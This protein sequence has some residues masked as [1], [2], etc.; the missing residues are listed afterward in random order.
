[1]QQPE[2]ARSSSFA[3]SFFQAG[4]GNDHL[5]DSYHDVNDAGG[6]G[7]G[8]QGGGGQAV[9]GSPDGGGS[10]GASTPMVQGADMQG[11]PRGAMKRRSSRRRLSRGSGG[12]SGRNLMQSAAAAA[13]AAAAVGED[14]P[15]SNLPHVG[16]DPKVDR[17]TSWYTDALLQ[18]GSDNLNAILGQVQDETREEANMDDDEVLEQY[19]IMAHV[20]ANI[21]VKENTGF[22][23]AEYE[24]R[25]K[26]QPETGKKGDYGSKRPKARLP[27]PRKVTNSTRASMKA[28]EPPM[29]NP[30]PNRRFIDQRTPRVPELCPGIVVRG[31]ASNL[32]D[33]EHVVRCLGCRSQLR[34]NMLATLVN[35]P[36]CST[37]SPASSTR[38]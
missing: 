25:R 33:G 6:Q 4:G 2:F 20:E 22:D 28:E 10:G 36:D 24:K 23:L 1:M 34:V 35:C 14:E 16:E 37:V 15:L 27:E 8:G 18:G 21:R 7:G 31:T 38:R 12:A 32:P 17:Q 30:R 9:G 29:P 11:N 3:R 13:A 5:D 26:L 19:R